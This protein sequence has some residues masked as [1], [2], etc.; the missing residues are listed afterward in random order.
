MNRVFYTL[1]TCLVGLTAGCSESEPPPKKIAPTNLV[2]EFNKSTDGSGKVDFTATA[3]D[4]EHFSFNFGDL[5]TGES[6]DG[7][8]SHNYAES[9]IYSIV[10]IARSAD[11]LSITKTVSVNI[12]VNEPTVPTA[13][14]TSPENYD[15]MT[16]VWADEF[17]GTTLNSAF[18]THETG[19]GSSGWGNNELEYYRAANTIVQNGYLT[20]KA[21]KEQMG[22]FNYTSSR[23][24]TKDK[25][26]FK[27]GRVDIRA[28]L[29][30]GKGIWPA[31]WMLGNNISETG[32]GWPKCGEIDIMEMV[33]GGAG[34]DNKTHGTIHYDNGGYVY[35]G[36]STTLSS[37]IFADEFHV[38]SLVWTDTK[39]AWY[40]DDAATPFK[41]FN[42]TDPKFDEFHKDFFF[43]FNVA[44][45]GN[46]PGSPNETTVFPQRMI[47]DYIRVFKPL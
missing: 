1:F 4:A 30:K 34:F 10:V 14:Y 3:T 11:Q 40:L 19:N 38:F 32:F 16:K 18:W 15:G 20:I 12:Q 37:G 31:L 35:E 46:W 26:V 9:G 24:I 5:T 17:E 28:L 8:I 47:V 33:G 13:G 7:V 29:P 43:I 27:Y 6:T 41:E 2:V 44:V 39:I 23:I 22:G 21:K 45:G 42:I 25:K 36:G